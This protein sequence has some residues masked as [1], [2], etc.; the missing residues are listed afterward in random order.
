MSQLLCLATPFGSL[1]PTIAH[2][3]SCWINK[4]R[5]GCVRAR[6]VIAR[7]ARDACHHL[8]LNDWF[9]RELFQI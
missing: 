8:W 6:Q 1:E 3:V 2:V 7:L 9:S 4:H 5:N